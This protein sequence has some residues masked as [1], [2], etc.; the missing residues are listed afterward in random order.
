MNNNQN[1]NRTP[2]ANRRGGGQISREEAILRARQRAETLKKRKERK[3]IT[4]KFVALFV[5]A[6]IG[7]C[8]ILALVFSYIFISFRSTESTPDEPV[9]ITTV[10][11]KTVVLDEDF[12]TYKSGEYFVSLTKVSEVCSFTLHGNS[13]R[14]T[15]TP[16]DNCHASFDIGTH[17]VEINNTYSILS[18]PSYFENGHLFIPAS[19]FSDY[20]NGVKCEF[21]KKGKVKGFNLLF[22]KNFDFKAQNT[23]EN[24]AV[25]ASI[26]TNAESSKKTKFKSD[27]SNY[28]MYM[29]PEDSDEFLLLVNSENPLSKKY[30]P[31]DLVDVSRTR[32]GL[33]KEQLRLYAAKALEAMFIEMSAN[34]FTGVYVTCGYTNYEYSETLYNNKVKALTPK[35]G[36]D[37]SEE[38]KKLVDIPGANEHQ[39]GLCV[40]MHN[41]EYESEEFATKD[42]YKWLYSN[43]AEFGFIVRYPKDKTAVT[44][45]SFE[46]WHFRYV[47]R[48]H[49]KKIMDSGL[50]LEEYLL[51]L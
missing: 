7:A 24:K 40:D 38:A 48:H 37:A 9:K 1:R 33:S 10:D 39:S 47:G 21:D 28:E 15:L 29:N 4:D 35:Y 46:P 20:C 12:Y 41:L 16:R 18:Q 2:S 45:K 11:D 36:K 8:I 30:V 26:Q 13:E 32:N 3:E 22:D 31:D 42:A 17:S 19:F 5:F 49:A 50:C 25:G 51:E 14:M 27:L 6:A 34:G 23:A 44:S 43:C